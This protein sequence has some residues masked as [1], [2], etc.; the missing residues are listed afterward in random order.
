M[1]R[2]GITEERLDTILE[3]VRTEQ[4]GDP[5]LHRDKLLTHLRRVDAG[6]L[7]SDG[8][9]NGNLRP[10]LLPVIM[11]TIISIVIGVA[12]L[13]S[14]SENS[15]VGDAPRGADRSTFSRGNLPDPTTPQEPASHP[16]AVPQAR[17]PADVTGMNVNENDPRGEEEMTETENELI[18]PALFLEDLTPEELERAFGIYVE[19]GT[20]LI[21]R[22][23]EVRLEDL[24]YRERAQ[25]AEKG[26]DTA[27]P[28]IYLESTYGYAPEGGEGDRELSEESQIDRHPAAELMAITFPDQYHRRSF[29]EQFRQAYGWDPTWALEG[30]YEWRNAYD[31][32]TSLPSSDSIAVPSL[33]GVR[34]PSPSHRTDEAYILWYAPTPALTELLPERYRE[35][36]ARVIP[37]ALQRGRRLSRA[38]AAAREK[39]KEESTRERPTIT[40][41]MV[42]MTASGRPYSPD[43]QH[44]TANNIPGVRYIDLTIEEGG[45]LG[46]GQNDTIITGHIRTHVSGPR[47]RSPLEYYGYPS[48]ADAPVVDFLCGVWSGLAK[49]YSIVDWKPEPVRME[50]ARYDIPPPLLFTAHVPGTEEQ[51]DFSMMVHPEDPPA[52]TAGSDPLF[53]KLDSIL[54]ERIRRSPQHLADGEGEDRT[55]AGVL[56]RM[57]PVRVFLDDDPSSMSAVFWYLPTDEFIERLP[58]RYRSELTNEIELITDA[59]TNQTELCD[60]VAG[61]R[62][63]LGLCREGGG[64]LLG[65]DVSPNPARG[66]GE[67]TI[68]L[69]LREKRTLRITLHDLS[70]AFISELRPFEPY[71]AGRHSVPASL[72]GVSAGTYLIA[73][74]SDQGDR[75]VQRLVVGG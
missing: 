4:P 34:L 61:D 14:G 55:I 65:T 10:Y 41:G 24:S 1:N 38:Y 53:R 40:L 29:S 33:V 49:T 51:P 20:Y 30:A 46:I 25:M 18:S 63:F 62:S 73:I 74:E 16:Q 68:D 2:N 52:S 15:V 17:V 32:G 31:D 37:E 69:T 54:D 36:A 44:E 64:A 58:Q 43:F 59:L 13:L 42:W 9:R 22:V 35:R 19:D 56:D 21:R 26:I 27:R 67:V 57:V 8:G 60:R 45:A 12:L 28:V 6:E 11:T 39:A 48:D 50:N 72:Q 3:T 7:T 23:R 75:G 47:W 70:G 66:Q 5:L 71:T